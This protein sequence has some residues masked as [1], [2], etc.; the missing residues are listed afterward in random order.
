MKHY[1][2]H[3]KDI[4][5]EYPMNAKIRNYLKLEYYINLL[6]KS[7]NLNFQEIVLTHLLNVSEI[8]TR[9]DYKAEIIKDIDKY[10]GSLKKWKKS[11]G[12][13]EQKIKELEIKLKQKRKELNESSHTGCPFKDDMFL[14]SINQR[15][16]ITGATC[17][18]D[19]PQLHHWIK[20]NHEES[21][22]QIQLWYEA[23][24]P[25][26]SS[27][28]IILNI[29]RD[30]CE[31]ETKSTTDGFFQHHQT[32]PIAI[33]KIRIKEGYYPSLS[34]YSNKFAVNIFQ[35]YDQKHY[36]KEIFFDLACCVEI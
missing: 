4:V 7:I 3:Q 18:F 30:S 34:G 2:D 20:S 17:S 25:I 35:F 1:T 16:S 36:N 28:D 32:S 13:D 31:Y 9:I 26:I 21:K 5:F 12:S 14:K 8:C 24:M 23:F 6:N 27:L 19:L 29:I 33:A 10:I 22:K 15:L 11:Q